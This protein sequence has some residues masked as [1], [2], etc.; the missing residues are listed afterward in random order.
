MKYMKRVGILKSNY[1]GPISYKW[2]FTSLACL[3]S[4]AYITFIK[5]DLYKI[6]INNL[7]PL[8]L[9]FVIN[10]NQIIFYRKTN[11]LIGSILNRIIYM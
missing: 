11:R 10:Y 8:I 6:K 2:S 7:K 4:I 1:A 3:W 9:S 5:Y